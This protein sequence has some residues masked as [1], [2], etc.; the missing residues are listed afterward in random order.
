MLLTLYT[1]IYNNCHQPTLELMVILLYYSIY[2]IITTSF[3]TF[4]QCYYYSL[5][6]GQWQYVIIDFV[7]GLILSQQFLNC[8]GFC[9]LLYTILIIRERERKL[10]LNWVNY[11]IPLYFQFINNLQA[12]YMITLTDTHFYIVLP[13]NKNL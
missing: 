12:S 8:F 5:I 1:L 6:F 3:C 2:C 10:F 9:F 7:Q 11:Y 4:L 13:W